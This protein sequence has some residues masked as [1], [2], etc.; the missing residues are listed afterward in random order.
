MWRE[1]VPNWPDAV[2]VSEAKR[3]MIFV[4]VEDTN[5]LTPERLDKYA[6]AFWCLDEAN[7]SMDLW[8]TDRYG[9]NVRNINVM[10]WFAFRE[11]ARE[12]EDAAG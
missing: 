2:F 10:Q 6:N 8:V 9:A 7:W 1:R 5:S 3:H 11:E 12:K 4:E